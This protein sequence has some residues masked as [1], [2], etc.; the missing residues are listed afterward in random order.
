MRPLFLAA[1][2]LSVAA[3]HGRNT[4][5]D[6]TSQPEPPID[7]THPGTRPLSRLNATEYDTTVGDL[8]GTE[9]HPGQNF[10]ADEIAYGFDNVASVLTTT[11]THVE[12]WELAAD[13]ILDEM[14]GRKDEST[15]MYGTQAE[16]AGVTY[17]GEGQLYGETAYALVDGSLSSPFALAFDGQFDVTVA[18]F[19]REVGGVSPSMEVR[20]DGELAE[21]FEVTNDIG[22]TE[23]FTFRTFIADGVHGFEVSIGNPGE[24]GGIP[25]ALMVDYLRI[26]GPMDPQTGRSPAYD[27]YVSCAP[28]GQP[29]RACARDGI[30]AFGGQAWRRP[31]TEA[32]VDWAV[33]LYESALD[34]NLDEGEALQYAFKGILVS[35]EFVYRIE[36]DPTGG[37]TYRALDGYEVATRLAA[38]AWSSTPDQALLDAAADG[39]LDTPEG[40]SAQLERMLADER[41]GAVLDNLAGQWFAM[42]KLSTAA[43][44]ATVYPEYTAD[45]R[46]S[47]M[48]ELRFIA[49]SFF[50]EGK[51]LDEMLLSQQT[52][53]DQRLADHYNLP[54]E[55][56]GAEGEAGFAEVSLSG[57]GRTGLFGSAGWLMANSRVNGPSAVK[58]GKWIVENLLCTPPPP[59]P[60]D[61]EGQV[62]IEPEG[63]ST[64]EQEEAQRGADYCQG[65]HSA[66]D[67][68]GFVLWNFDG[69]GGKR[70]KDELGFPIDTESELGGVT[71]SNGEDLAEWV[72]ADPRLSRCV[73]EKTLTYALGRPMEL[74][75]NKVVDE[76]TEAFDAGG[77]TFDALARA[78]VVSDAFR[79]RGA[80]EVE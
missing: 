3:C 11:T 1:L 62:T 56:T 26:D 55:G 12:S 60:P 44:D 10:P 40:V 29:N 58:R 20:I 67:P 59:P 23:E 5:P 75:D 41:G 79:L 8:V 15:S 30:E 33:S 21:T 38:F 46:D 6:G 49:S 74:A 14:F 50:R 80:P 31:L 66:M 69:I 64:R 27:D 51:P 28:D 43:T 48:I 39:T 71:L 47:M 52:W 18:A 9:L 72:V 54:Y 70:S 42:R 16:A 36:A 24:S 37:A 17:L 25:R 61:V 45:L 65:C 63:G 13:E 7:D 19:G 2:T 76:I 78:I 68:L 22:A 57:T 53:V 35:P 73:V 34:A 4:E 77:Q 32:E